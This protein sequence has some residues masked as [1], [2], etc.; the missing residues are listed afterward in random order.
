MKAKKE[1]WLLLMAFVLP[2][3]LGSVF[4]YVNPNYFSQNT[5]NYGKFI[6]P[7]ITTQKRDIVFADTKAK[8]HG[9]WNLVYLSN[10]CD[11][12]CQT[13]LK[14]MKTIRLLMN[15][16]MRRL[17][18]ILL[19]DKQIDASLPSS[20]SQ[21]LRAKSSADLGQKL[22]EFPDN[23]LFLIDPIGNVMLYYN[24]LDLNIKRVIRDLKR[25]FKYSRIG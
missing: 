1:L 5:V 18:V 21:V 23:T 8:L 19:S 2:I 10:D 3:V 7:I 4:F 17:Q 11:G 20:L 15:D 25:L 24:A 16:N 13:A 6:T 22:A 12:I 14:E 9:L